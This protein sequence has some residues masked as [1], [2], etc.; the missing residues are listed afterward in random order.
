MEMAKKALLIYLLAY[1][2]AHAD[3]AALFYRRPTEHTAFG[4]TTTQ[5]STVSARA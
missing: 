2:S 3:P 5:A 4:A 1:G